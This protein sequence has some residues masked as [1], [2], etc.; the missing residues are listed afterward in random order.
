MGSLRHKKKTRSLIL[1]VVMGIVIFAAGVF[2][3]PLLSE[4]GYQLKEWVSRP[5]VPPPALKAVKLYFGVPGE[6]YLS[7]EERRI[8][9]VGISRAMKLLYLS[10]SHTYLGQQAKK[11]IFLDEITGTKTPEISS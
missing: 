10:Y 5:F 11:S 2:S 6:D 7:L 1:W 9:F 3:S 8:V 4:K